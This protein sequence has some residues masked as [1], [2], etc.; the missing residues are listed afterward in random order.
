MRWGDGRTYCLASIL[1]EVVGRDEVPSH[2]LVETGIAMVSSINHR[3]LEATRVLEV[4]MKLTIL[5]A[6]GRC[7]T[8]TNVCLE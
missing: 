7:S 3:V 6:I 4:Q 1:G 5:A 2:T 8:G